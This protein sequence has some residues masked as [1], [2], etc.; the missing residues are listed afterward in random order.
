MT[1]TVWTYLTY[2]LITVPLTV[3]VARTLSRNGQVFL[4]DVFEDKIE[5]ADAVNQLL[6]VGFYLLNIG[7]VMLYLRMGSAVFDL[8]GLLEA[9]SIKVG[10][11]MLMLGVI[12]FM[13]VYVFNAIR[14]RSRAESLRTPPV[15]PQ[16]NAWATPGYPPP[17][18]QSPSGQPR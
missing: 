12:H 2:L 13:N 17:T 8:T 7:F 9:L 11:V 5:L 10:F 3:W 18:G 4:A 1:W 16:S 15:A 14:R 6:V